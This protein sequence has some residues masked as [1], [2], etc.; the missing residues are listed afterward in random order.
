MGIFMTVVVGFL[1]GSAAKYLMPGDEGGGFIL[2]TLLGV[3]GAFVG[4]FLGRFV[5]IYTTS[6]LGNFLGATVGA[7]VLLFVYNKFKGKS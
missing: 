4:S 1:A 7:V 2:T 6:L 5:G 3:G